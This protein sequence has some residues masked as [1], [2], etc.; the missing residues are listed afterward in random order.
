MPYCKQCGNQVSDV[1]VSCPECG[2]TQ[3]KESGSHYQQRPYQR[4]ND[5]GGFG[6]GLLGFCVPLAGLILYLVWKDERPRTANAVGGGALLN[7]VLG[8]LLVF[9]AFMFSA[10]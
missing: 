4:S 8:L 2:A 9:M 3:R 10:V 5:V 6:W 7:V 1:A